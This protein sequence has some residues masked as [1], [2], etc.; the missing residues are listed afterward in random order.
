MQK[1]PTL[2]VKTV[3][4]QHA[5]VPVCLHW[6]E[7][8]QWLLM[9]CG[10]RQTLPLPATYW[11][12]AVEWLCGDSHNSKGGKEEFSFK[13]IAHWKVR[14]IPKPIWIMWTFPL[15][16]ERKVKQTAQQLGYPLLL[17]GS[18]LCIVCIIWPDVFIIR[19]SFFVKFHEVL[20]KKKKKRKKAVLW[21]LWQ[22]W[23]PSFSL[24][25]V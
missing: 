25:N 3:S 9:T 22:E 8:L 21:Q 12:A 2:F 4:K 6:T 13:R 7:L 16:A 18:L 17:L 23:L 14:A 10:R 1:L 5:C 19:W 15:N 20:K 11:P 24:Y